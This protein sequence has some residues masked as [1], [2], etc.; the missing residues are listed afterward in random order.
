MDITLPQTLFVASKNLWYFGILMVLSFQAIL[1]TTNC[2]YTLHGPGTGMGLGP[3]TISL[4]SMPS[5]VHT[6]Q[7]Q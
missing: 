6:T 7:G 3:A 2:S 1:G 5:T 4:Y